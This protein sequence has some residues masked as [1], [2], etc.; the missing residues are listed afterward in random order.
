MMAKGEGEH[1]WFA[2]R[3]EIVAAVLCTLGLPRPARI[4]EIGCGTGGNLEMLSHFGEVTAV[5]MASAARALIRERWKGPLIEGWLPDGL[6]GLAPDF[7]LV[8]ML[9]VLEHIEA[10]SESLARVMGLLKPGGV[11][12]LTA[13][14][15]PSLWSHYDT[16]HHHFR[17]YRLRPLKRQVVEAGFEVLRSTYFSTLL[18]PLIAGIR[19]VERFT[20]LRPPM[21]ELSVP[22]PLLNRTLRMIFSSE[23]YLVPRISL[24]FGTSV[25]VSARR[26]G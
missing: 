6:P 3:R 5:E 2:S 20:G 10:D 19:L 21:D 25:L 22:P 1:W 8:V 12:L 15:F 7:D 11:L 26:R 18:F 9:D 23:R 24:P 14:A 17:R 16:R 13:P 4:M